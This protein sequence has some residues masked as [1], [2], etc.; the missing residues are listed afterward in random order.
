MAFKSFKRSRESAGLDGQQDNNASIPEAWDQIQGESTPA[1]DFQAVSQTETSEPTSGKDPKAQDFLR[2]IHD[3]KDAEI[4]LVAVHGLN[5]SNTNFHAEKTWTASNNSMWLKDFLPKALPTARV[6]LFGYNANVAFQTSIAGV[7]EQ[8]ENLLNRLKGKRKNAMERP[9]I[10]ICHS[11]GGLIVKRALITSK[12]TDTYKSIQNATYGIAF[13][14]TPHRGGNN[15]ALGSIAASI[16][17]C[18]LKNPTNTF[19]EALKK[20]SLFADDLVQDFRQ[21]LED[22]YILSFFET[23]PMKKYGLIADQESATLGLPLDRE[24]QIAL[25]RDHSHICKFE[26]IESDDYEQVIENIEELAKTALQAVEEKARMTALQIPS[27]EKLRWVDVTEH[28]KLENPEPTE[29]TGL[30]MLEHEDFQSW[31]YGT[32]KMMWWR[33][34]PGAG[35]TVLTTIAANY[36]AKSFDDKEIP[37]AC[38]FCNYNNRENQVA[39][40]I[41]SSILRQVLEARCT[42]PDTVASLYNKCHTA[43]GP[44]FKELSELLRSSL[45]GT[46]SFFLIDA[47][48]ECSEKENTSGRV[49]TELIKL[50]SIPGTRLL[51]TSRDE[52]PTD[53]PDWK[54]MK[55]LKIRAADQDVR[56][57][58]DDYMSQSHDLRKHVRAN[59]NLRE[60][61]ITTISEKCQG[62]FLLA[63]YYL[64][65]LARQISLRGV[66]DALGN[67]PEKLSGMYREIEQ[68]IEK[69]DTA[70]ADLAWKILRWL[71]YTLRPLTLVEISEALAV[72]LGSTELDENAR[73]YSDRI[74]SVCAGLVTIDQESTVVRF[75]HFSAQEHLKQRSNEAVEEAH[76]EMAAICLTYLSFEV[77]EEGPRDT[78]R[79]LK[80]RLREFPLLEYSAAH[81]GIHARRGWNGAVQQ[82]TLELL[83]QYW[84]RESFVQVILVQVR[85]NSMFQPLVTESTGLC[86]AAFFGL[87]EVAILLLNN[88][89]DIDVEGLLGKTALYIAVSQGH[90]KMVSLLLEHGANVF[91]PT[92]KGRYNS[93]YELSE[94]SPL[95]R[96]SELGHEKIVRC[97]LI[98]HDDAERYHQLYRISLKYAATSGH[99]EIVR[100]LLDKVMNI[101]GEGRREL[102]MQDALVK[103]SLVGHYQIV[104]QLLEQGAQVNGQ[105]GDSE[106]A[107]EAASSWGHDQVVRLLLNHGAN[108]NPPAPSY[109][110]PLTI[111]SANGYVSTVQ[112]LLEHKA[113]VNASNWEHKTA[114]SSALHAGH[115]EVIRLLFAH[116]ADVNLDVDVD[117]KDEMIG[118]GNTVLNTPWENGHRQIIEWLLDNPADMTGKKLHYALQ[119]ASAGG[120]DQVVKQLLQLGVDMN[121]GDCFFSTVHPASQNGHAQVV[122][123]LLQNGVDVKDK[124]E[125]ATSLFAASRNGHSQVVKLLLEKTA[126]LNTQEDKD[127]ALIQA[128]AEGH[129]SIV[130]QLLTSGAEVDSQDDRRTP[131][132]EA[133]SNGHRHVVKLLLQMG[134]DIDLPA[135]YQHDYE[136]MT[137]NALQ[138]ASARGHHEIVRLLLEN[139]ASVNASVGIVGYAI[140]AASRNGDARIVQLLLDAGADIDACGDYGCALAVASTKGHVHMVELLLNN[141]AQV[142]GP[143]G[144]DY[145]CALT[146]ASAKGHVRVVE[147]LLDNRAQVNGPGGKYSCALTA[148]S[149]NGYAHVVE[150]LLDNRAQADSNTL[151]AASRVGYTRIVQYLL[152]AGG[153]LLTPEEGHERTKAL[154]S[155]SHRGHQATVHQLLKAGADVDAHDKTLGNALL[156][157]SVRGH[158]FVVRRLLEGGADVNAKVACRFR[159]KD[160]DLS[161]D[162]DPCE[163]GCTA[164]MVA[165]AVGYGQIVRLLLENG[166]D[167]NTQGVCRRRKVIRRSK[168]DILCGNALL[169]AVC[170]GHELIVQQLLSNGADVNAQGTYHRYTWSI[171]DGY[172]PHPGISHGSALHAASIEGYDSIVQ[173]LLQNGADVMAKDSEGRTPL[174]LACMEDKTST[175]ELLLAERA[176]VQSA[177][178]CFLIAVYFSMAC[179]AGKDVTRKPELKELA[180]LESVTSYL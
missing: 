62:M 25:D 171:R 135:Q 169:A 133:A 173:L 31:V 149:A 108:I 12:A 22:Y 122:H 145:D 163:D 15:T 94:V 159:Q 47:F 60:E 68:R 82:Q 19:M 92:G 20:D 165:S 144:G 70:E 152:K 8:A 107:L 168:R 117:L 13:F 43:R 172:C 176:R 56:M 17:R 32:G 30:W 148:A 79:D 175:V 36:L 116:G 141:H 42:I 73:P 24:K 58:F 158:T 74:V 146:A 35:K 83:Q 51:V 164:L 53:I 71:T 142:D 128:S 160:E 127:R 143:G 48:D 78:L 113:N 16:A 130:Q 86:V 3:P 124:K 88:G 96:A 77:F 98:H 85:R 69:Q 80:I 120:C 99:Q 112:L 37:I 6:L 18:A 40:N 44:T 91:P 28:A 90:E 125:H 65:L 4:D 166:A 114:L 147:L 174:T 52:P 89:S 23:R 161:E 7:R 151:I 131:L 178:A 87:D 119:A 155:A 81:W 126:H 64:E 140:I 57:Y 41:L 63:R 14:A 5:H 100:L 132:V 11:L 29:G 66:Y 103:A 111:A 167:P 137:V 93:S 1:G 45:S 38:I 115:L 154:I 72:R 179:E 97:L 106:S 139:R 27:P 26:S 118:W 180:I 76:N 162:E 104:R 50:H 95:I 136:E 177:T 110:Y 55:R 67:L 84:K 153:N 75:V 134:A 54:G 10:F 49:L 157:A 170:F 105:G 46:K 61:I 9:I 138:S 33:G 129:D 2:V 150:L 39:T 59:H 121:A 102:V 123:T 21:Q 34:Q 156:A 101:D 109:G